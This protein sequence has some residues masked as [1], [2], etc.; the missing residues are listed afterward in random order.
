M[1]LISASVPFGASGLCFAHFVL[2]ENHVVE[3]DDHR[4][5]PGGDV[6]LFARARRDARGHR[7][8]HTQD[9]NPPRVHAATPLLVK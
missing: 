8:G 7:N 6:V 9:Q 4:L 3:L 5:V 2:L 1:K